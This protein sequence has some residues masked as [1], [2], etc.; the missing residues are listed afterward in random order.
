MIFGAA[1]LHA[2]RQLDNY[3]P[4]SSG[5]IPA[6]GAELAHDAVNA[7]DVQIWTKP[8]SA[9]RRRELTAQTTTPEPFRVLDSITAV[10]CNTLF[11]RRLALPSVLVVILFLQKVARVRSFPLIAGPV[12]LVARFAG[13]LILLRILRSTP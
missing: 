11:R 12:S 4:R 7:R 6:P 13:A 9:F 3:Q 8:P 5:L 2:A 1:D 10:L